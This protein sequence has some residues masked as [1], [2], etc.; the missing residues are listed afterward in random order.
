S[1]D[2]LE[3]LAQAVQDGEE[4]E[5]GSLA[6]QAIAEKVDP[7]AAVDA[8]T[9]AIRQVGDRFERM[10]IFL[11]EMML[12]AQ[13]MQKALEPITPHLEAH[14]A[15][16][17]QKGTVVLGTVEGDIH[18]IGKSIVGLLLEVNGYAVHD[19]GPDVN[20]L[21][22][23]KTAQEVDADVI[24][25]SALMTTTM[26]GQQ[27]IIELLKDMGL[28][29]RFLVVVGGTPVT[30]AWAEEIGADGWAENAMQAVAV[31]EKLMA[32]RRGHAGST[33]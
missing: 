30:D 26:P 25:G 22:F 27:E 28:R 16:R 5:A 12:A 29:E 14:K 21:D 10:E 13:A 6:E 11:P 33:V 4:E 17:K 3:K 24:G 8:L 15:Q 2:I 32:A 7:L 19:L 1:M 31:L 23:I 18:E 20:A 9:E